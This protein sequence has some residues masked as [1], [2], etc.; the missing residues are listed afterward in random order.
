M[1][2]LNKQKPVDLHAER[3]KHSYQE[4]LEILLSDPKAK[5]ENLESLLDHLERNQ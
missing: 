4:I 5:P 2:I 3:A 1:H